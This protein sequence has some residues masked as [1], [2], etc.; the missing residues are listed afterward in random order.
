[1]NRRKVTY[2]VCFPII[3]VCLLI[4]LLGIGTIFLITLVNE[5]KVF[6][7]LSFR[8]LFFPVVLPSVLFLWTFIAFVPQIT[9]NSV[10]LEKHLCGIPLKKYKWEDIQDIKIIETAFGISWLFF[11]KSNLKNHGIDYCRLHPKTIYLAIDD[12]KLQTI[13]EFIPRDKIIREHKSKWLE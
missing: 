5:E 9:F 6:E 12:K 3:F 10:G 4:L 2:Y 1:M 11:S 8:L 13:K 7:I